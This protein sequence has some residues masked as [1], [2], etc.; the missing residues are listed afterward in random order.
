MGLSEPMYEYKYVVAGIK[1][2]PKI[3][4][5]LEE[6]L[7]TPVTGYEAAD[8]FYDYFRLDKTSYAGY[9]GL[10]DATIKTE[11]GETVIF[12]IKTTGIKNLNK[13]EVGGLPPYYVSQLQTYLSAW[14]IKH[15][16]TPKTGVLVACFL[17]DEDYVKPDTVSVRNREIRTYEVPYNPDMTQTMLDAIS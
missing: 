4:K 17:K 2:E 10:P 12:E 5:W 13:W 15:G 14:G 7:N 1:I 9:G 16:R 6:E 11:D 8:Y 3:K